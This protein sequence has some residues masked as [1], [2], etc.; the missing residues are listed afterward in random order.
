MGG[1]KNVIVTTVEPNGV[2]VRVFPFASVTFVL[3]CCDA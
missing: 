3:L 1:E 2:G